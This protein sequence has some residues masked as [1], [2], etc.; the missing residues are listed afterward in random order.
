MNLP[1]RDKCPVCGSGLQMSFGHGEPND[2]YVCT[3]TAIR[4][5]SSMYVH[6]YMNYH[7]CYRN[8]ATG[9]DISESIDFG[10]DYLILLTDNKLSIYGEIVG[11][12]ISVGHANFR[13]K[14]K[15]H[16]L[17]DQSIENLNTTEK[18]INFMILL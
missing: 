2:L 6:D 5:Q 16:V 12:R 15:M 7:Y 14:I 3:A 9:F 17:F 18:L 1:I 10:D 11:S 8:N 13:K 4:N